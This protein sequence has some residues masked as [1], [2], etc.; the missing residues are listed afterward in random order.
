MAHKSFNPA[1]YKLIPFDPVPFFLVI[2]GLA[3][4]INSLVLLGIVLKSL[5]LDPAET[6]KK[7]IWSGEGKGLKNPCHPAR[8]SAD[9]EYEMDVGIGSSIGTMAPSKRA[10]PLRDAVIDDDEPAVLGQIWGPG[11]AA[12]RDSVG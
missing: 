9:G 11:G 4:I 8:R 10:A 3:I 7:L 6:I 1:P 5:N 2:A 12:M